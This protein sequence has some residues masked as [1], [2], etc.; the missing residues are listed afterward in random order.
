MRP[1]SDLFETSLR[2]RSQALLGNDRPRSSASPHRRLCNKTI[3]PEALTRSRA[4]RPGVPKQSLGTRETRERGTRAN[5]GE[6]P[7]TKPSTATRTESDSM[8][9]I[10]VP[11]D[12]YWGAQTQ[13]SLEHFSIGTDRMPLEIIRAFGV[14]KKA[15]ALVNLSL[16]K[17]PKEK[18]DLIVRAADEV[19]AGKLD[20]HF[21]LF[22]WQTG[23]GTQTNMNANEVIANRAIELAG[24]TMGSKNPIHPNDHVNLSQSSNDT[25]PTAMHIAA[26]QALINQLVPTVWWLRDALDAKAREFA[27]VV[28]I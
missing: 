23:S 14:L 28:K 11:A 20:G 5:G 12:R 2:P 19:I 4:S 7:M 26:A 18:A 15:A 22:V 10:E 17:L 24:G 25:F 16:G 3:S 13:R 27:D 1:R 6:T 21:P 8:G 9:K